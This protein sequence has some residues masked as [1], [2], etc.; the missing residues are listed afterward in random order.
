MFKDLGCTK[1]FSTKNA[2]VCAHHAFK[3]N[4]YGGAG[5]QKQVSR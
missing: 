1:R 2:P 3:V 5:P 4:Y